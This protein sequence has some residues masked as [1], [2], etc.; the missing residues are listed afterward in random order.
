[1]GFTLMQLVCGR[2]VS[3]PH[4][5]GFHWPGLPQLLPAPVHI[6]GDSRVACACLLPQVTM[7]RSFT[8]QLVCAGSQPA[9]TLLSWAA[10]SSLSLAAPSIVSR[11]CRR[12]YPQAP[13][14]SPHRKHSSKHPSLVVTLQESA[15]RPVSVQAAAGLGDDEELNMESLVPGQAPSGYQTS[16]TS[17]LA[18]GNLLKGNQASPLC[19][20]AGFHRQG[21]RPIS[22]QMLGCWWRVTVAVLKGACS[23]Q[24]KQQRLGRSWA[25]SQPEHRAS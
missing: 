13:R 15:R 20:A 24:V 7:R 16:Q 8:L 18:E 22:R 10:L 23:T 12:R 25:A 14:R 4:C 19:I 2:V 21:S 1:M 6:T 9:Y 5:R 3:P 11:T 17:Q